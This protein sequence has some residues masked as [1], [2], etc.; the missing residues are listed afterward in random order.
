M[1]RTRLSL[2]LSQGEQ[3]KTRSRS[4]NVRKG[5]KRAGLVMVRFRE[6]LSGIRLK[7]ASNNGIVARG[8]NT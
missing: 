5:R 8:S 6:I 3:G 7:A 4:I 2:S 1:N